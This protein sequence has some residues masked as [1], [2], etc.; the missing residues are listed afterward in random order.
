MIG[1]HA[2]CLLTR[3]LA[4]RAENFPAVGWALLQVRQEEEKAKVREPLTRREKEHKQM[5][6]E[7][8]DVSVPDVPCIRDQSWHNEST[9][10]PA[11]KA[12]V[13]YNM[14][15]S[16]KLRKKLTCDY[17]PTV[18][19]YIILVGFVCLYYQLQDQMPTVTS[20]PFIG[21]MPTGVLRKPRPPS[22]ITS[23]TKRS[24]KRKKIWALS[25]KTLQ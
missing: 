2:V 11:G 6:S 12:R 9:R 13:V 22:G 3:D 15:C 14:M 21:A 10:T 25:D 8:S 17:V 18:V 16:T 19:L 4:G 1:L 23:G 20:R 5:E 7:L 24:R